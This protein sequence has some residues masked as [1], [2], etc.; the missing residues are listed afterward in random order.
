MVY[1]KK[2]SKKT[3]ISDAKKQIVLLLSLLLLFTVGAGTALAFLIDGPKSIIN[4]FTPS[5]VTCKVDETFKN[6]VK[7]DVK[8]KN[9]GDTE[10]YIRAAVIVTWQDSNGNVS[11][12]A[13]VKD[14]DYEITYQLSDTGWIKQ[15]D[16]YYYK[17]PVPPV[18][19]TGETETGKTGVLISSCRPL[20]AGPDGYTLHVEIIAEAIQAVPKTAVTEAWGK[21]IADQLN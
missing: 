8:I 16:F 21:T 19:T 14:M 15:G 1:L 6:N 10:A 18:S 13:P 11:A 12:I 3:N 2:H 17:N 7:S 20:K 9:T 5:E 4:T